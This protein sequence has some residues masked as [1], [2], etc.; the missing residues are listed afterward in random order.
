MPTPA[1]PPLLADA[2]VGGRVVVRFVVDTTGR[3]E[4]ATISVLASPHPALS[5]AVR[6]ALV[7]ARFKP[8]RSHGTSVRVLG[9][10]TV[11]FRRVGN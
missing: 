8:G 5:D 1:Y 7:K 6:E 10:I 11:T 3:V 9:E 2:G 4:P